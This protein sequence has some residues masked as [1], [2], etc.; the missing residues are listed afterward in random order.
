MDAPL[1]ALTRQPAQLPGRS[2]QEAVIENM[3]LLIQLRWI[4]V[5]G[6]VVAILIAYHGLGVRLPLEEMLSVAGLLAV[7][8][9]LFNLTLRKVWV[10]PGELMLALLLDMAALTAQLYLSGG[11]ENPFIS[12]YLLQIVLGAILLPA[13]RAWLLVL[14]SVAAFVFLTFHHLPLNLPPLG[15]GDLDLRLLGEE[16]A[17]IMVAVLLVQFMTRISRN[18]RARDAYVAELRQ[19]AA[20]EDSIVRMGLFA[21]GAAHELGTPLSSLSV[22]VGDWQRDPKLAHDPQFVEELNDA[23]TAVERCREIVSDILDTSGLTRGEAMGSVAA[24]S[25]LEGLV[26]DWQALHMDVP[27]SASFAEVG[28]ARV[29][30]EPALRQ[31]I[32]SLLENGGEVSPGGIDMAGRVENEQLVVE[33]FDRGRGF[34]PHELARVGQISC[35]R[36]GSGHG[37][38]LFLASNVARRLGGALTAT[39]RRGGGAAVRLSLPL[40]GLGKVPA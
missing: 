39:N 13:S 40:V 22:L 21:S 34:L 26:A 33:V 28:T 15:A 1:L 19:R 30:A 20:E 5:L 29:P 16:V 36:K 18:L 2:P 12:L 31:A 32:W 4:A 9:I 23:R 17:F 14:V 7:G 37:L 11:V 6:Q 24:A 27:L 8:N 38:G 35:S 10:V 25:L 3:R